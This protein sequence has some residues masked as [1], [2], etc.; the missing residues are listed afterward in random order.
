MEHKE[1]FKHLIQ[2]I[3]KAWTKLT[4]LQFTGNHNIYA[5]FF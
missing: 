2:H 5:Y 1:I 3:E 4:E